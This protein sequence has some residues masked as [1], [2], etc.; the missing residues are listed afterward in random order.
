MFPMSFRV[1]VIAHRGISLVGQARR[2]ISPLVITLGRN[3]SRESGVSCFLAFLFYCFFAFL[4]PRFQLPVT[5]L[6]FIVQT[7][8]QGKSS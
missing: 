2:E 3:D 1:S 6:Y 5:P 8:L 4:F 7:T